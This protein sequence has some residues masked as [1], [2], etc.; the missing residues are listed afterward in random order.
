MTTHLSQWKCFRCSKESFGTAEALGTHLELE[1]SDAVT[2]AQRELVVEACESL[3]TDFASDA[4]PLCEDWQPEHLH[5]NTVAFFQ[6][7]ARHMPYLALL[8]LPPSLD[9][10]EIR[11]R[12]E[13]LARTESQD[14]KGKEVVGRRFPREM[15]FTDYF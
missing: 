2:A 1:H 10:L 14:V 15:H 4:C 8:A 12:K 9:G 3:K 5:D 6:H 7:V 11:P 13:D